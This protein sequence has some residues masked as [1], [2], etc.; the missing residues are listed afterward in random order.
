MKRFCAA[1]LGLS[2]LAGQTVTAA[3]PSPDE[4][5]KQVQ[6]ESAGK[7]GPQLEAVYAKVLPALIA[8]P[9]TDDVALQK[10]AFYASRPGADAERA[11]LCNLLATALAKEQ[12]TPVKV[13]LLRHLQR[14]GRDESVAAIVKA[15][16]DSDALVRESARRALANN[17]SRAAADAFKAEID[18]AT[19]AKWKAALVTALGYRRD[20][21]DAATFAKLVESADDV[22]RL[23]A[24]LA[25]GRTGDASAATVLAAAMQ[26]GSDA[27]KKAATD[28]YL[29]LADR[30]AASGQKDQALKIYSELLKST[31]VVRCAAIVG[32]G[33]TGSAEQAK[34]LFALLADKD[35]QARGAALEALSKF[36]DPTI[37][38]EIVAALPKVEAGA[39]P[40]F[41]RALLA[42]KEAK[43]HAKWFAEAANDVDPS[44][45]LEAI[46]ALAT[47]G[48]GP[49][50]AALV[51]SASQKIDDKAP[52]ALLLKEEQAA[53][54]NTLEMMPG[55]DVD[56]ALLG[57]L[58]SGETPA[59]V[60]V[61]KAIG[62]RRSAGSVD[63]LFA[64]ATD[65]DSSIRAEAFKAL[66]IVADFREIDKA[67]KLMISPKEENDRN[68]VGTM[69]VAI[70]RKNDNA[71][72]RIAPILAAAEKAEGA[73]KAA[74]LNAVGQIGGDKALAAIRT[75]IKSPDEKTHEAGVRALANWPDASPLSDLLALAKEEKNNTLS[76]LALRGYIRIL[77]LP[78]QRKVDESLKLYKDAMEAAKRP[79]EKKSVLGGVGQLKDPKALEF[80][81]TFLSDSALAAEACAAAVTLGKDTADKN[82]QLTKEV[83]QKV[84]EISKNDNQ[85][86]TAKETLDKIAAKEKK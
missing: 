37:T 45:R 84:L 85:K 33:N 63:P 67:L 86:K 81:Q 15:L 53:A 7:S 55:T 61:I 32:L 68:N 56:S 57:L 18:K 35:I 39:K 2:L 73:T 22:V 66:S 82:P 54:R 10:I 44:V 50:V 8:K 74:L 48:S 77:A 58:P 51:K 28:A 72:Q 70:A 9:E 41:L 83:M 24:L 47:V 38:A 3:D 1:V 5:F 12:V 59:R 26:K 11:A 16:S 20:A 14:I 60:E 75:A 29:I 30:L 78:H 21:A 49:S 13:L 42:R 62:A 46:K 71:D 43:E 64:A 34:Q 36:Q 25:L 52:N 6:T 17:P 80:V 76:I 31:G 40:W 4:L 19:D 65:A 79:D 69:L 23:P 27:A